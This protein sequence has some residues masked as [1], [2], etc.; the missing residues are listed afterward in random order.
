M[1]NKQLLEYDLIPSL[2]L[3]LSLTQSQKLPHKVKV[4]PYLD[5]LFDHIISPI[6]MK[7]LTKIEYQTYS[8]KKLPGS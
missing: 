4:A 7:S 1:P 2:N 5:A 6:N 8:K 3:S